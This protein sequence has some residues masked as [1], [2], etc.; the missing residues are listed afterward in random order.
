MHRP[1]GFFAA[2]ILAGL[3]VIV[4]ICFAELRAD[5]PLSPEECRQLYLRELDISSKD[6]LH[7]QRAALEKARKELLAEPVVRA[8]VEFCRKTISRDS[9][10]CA[11]KAG[12]VAEMVTCRMRP[13]EKKQDPKDPLPDARKDPENPRETTIQPLDV[14]V[15]ATACTRTYTHLVS[16]Y[17]S[18][19]I[20]KKRPDRDKLIAHWKSKTAV[21][22]FQSRC[23]ATFRPQD[24]GCI[25]STRDPDVIQGCLLVAPELKK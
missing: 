21:D 5:A 22:S 7:P 23:M 14:K 1:L 11:L 6:P 20:L 18:S 4:G 8:Q 25:L 15:D 17:E 13:P 9:Y 16:V 2:A 24:L 19:E 12:S 3:A 10:L